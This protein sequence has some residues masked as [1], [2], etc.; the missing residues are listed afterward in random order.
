MRLDQ[1]LAIQKGD[2]VVHPA[3]LDYKKGKPVM[4]PIRVTDV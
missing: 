4:L 2:Y 3:K 1:A